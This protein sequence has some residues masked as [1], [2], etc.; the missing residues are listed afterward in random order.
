MSSN[1]LPAIMLN[2][3]SATVIDIKTPAQAPLPPDGLDASENRLEYF[4]QVADG[5]FRDTDAEH[6][7]IDMSDS[8]ELITGVSRI[9]IKENHADTL[10]CR[11][12]SNP[13]FGTVTSK[14]WIFA[15]LSS[16]S[17]L[18]VKGLTAS[19]VCRPAEKHYSSKMES[20]MDIAASSS[21]SQRKSKPNAEPKHW[22]TPS[23]N[24]PICSSFG[25]RTTG[26]SYR[27]KNSGN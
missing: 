11:I 1:R 8:V 25:N 24:S 5:W 9:G 3:R 4:A 22:R 15:R 21:I 17:S 6:R 19:T 16:I 14:P 12:R 23:R 13:P 7:F 2:H 20:F 26:S 10:A 27:T 18:P